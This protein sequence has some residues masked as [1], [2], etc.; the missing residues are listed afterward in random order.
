[1]TA[2][3][4]LDKA[5][6]EIFMEYLPPGCPRAPYAKSGEQINFAFWPTESLAKPSSQPRMTS[7]F[8]IWKMAQIKTTRS[9]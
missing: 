1:M 7:P 6:C 9:L 5:I 8:P 4:Y 2:M 3:I